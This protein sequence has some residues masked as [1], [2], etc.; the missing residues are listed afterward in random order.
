MLPLLLLLPLSALR[1]VLMLTIE[2]FPHG[3]QI[4]GESLLTSVVYA[5]LAG[6]VTPQ[7]PEASESSPWT[8]KMDEQAILCD[9]EPQIEVNS[10]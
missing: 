2:A 10:Q 1:S 4:V 9:E 8:E 3:L 7:L 5:L 6:P